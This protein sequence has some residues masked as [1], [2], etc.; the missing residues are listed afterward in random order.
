VCERIGGVE[1]EAH[2]RPQLTQCH[3]DLDAAEPRHFHTQ[4][5]KLRRPLQPD[6]SP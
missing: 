3:R 4:E 2:L 6:L 5:R 1:C